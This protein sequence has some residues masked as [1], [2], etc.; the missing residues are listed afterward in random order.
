MLESKKNSKSW[1]LT[2]FLP[3]ESR[4]AMLKTSPYRFP[5][6]HLIN[7][8]GW[9]Q[10]YNKLIFKLLFGD[11]VVKK[12]WFQIYLESW[13]RL[14]MKQT[15]YEQFELDSRKNLFIFAYLENKSGSRLK[16]KI[17]Y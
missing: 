6:K 2:F 13:V 5:L 4:L 9:F 10:N 17:S 7:V 8:I 16:F 1:S 12:V 15:V 11:Y 3:I 14:Y